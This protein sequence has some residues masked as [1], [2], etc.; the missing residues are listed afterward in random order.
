MIRN[1]TLYWFV[2]SFCY[3][4]LCFVYVGL[5]SLRYVAIVPVVIVVFGLRCYLRPDWRR[6][7]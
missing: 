6:K 5:L 2:A 7:Q 4:L 3:V 1:S